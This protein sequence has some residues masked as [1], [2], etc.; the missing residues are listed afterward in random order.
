MVLRSGT[1]LSCRGG[2]ALV[3]HI[4]EIT[5][6]TL[7]PDLK[8]PRADDMVF[9]RGARKLTAW[10]TKHPQPHLDPTLNLFWATATEGS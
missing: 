7:S 6:L 10:M 3:R 2:V 4:E 8:S 5:N 1:Y 9:G